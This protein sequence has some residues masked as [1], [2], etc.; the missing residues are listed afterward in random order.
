MLRLWHPEVP[1]AA[2][3]MLVDVLGARGLDGYFNFVGAGESAAHA[4]MAAYLGSPQAD[5]DFAA[6]LKA[7]ASQLESSVTMRHMGQ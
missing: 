2:R 7:A 5:A 1:V 6:T 4:R 3:R